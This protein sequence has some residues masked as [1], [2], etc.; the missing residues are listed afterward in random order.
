MP[1]QI[2]IKDEV[3]HPRQILRGAAEYISEHGWNQGDFRDAQTGAVCAAGGIFA[4][5]GFEYDEDGL[6][7]SNTTYKEY[8]AE[9]ALAMLADSVGIVPPGHSSISDIPEWNDAPERT[10]EDVILAMKRA[11]E[12]A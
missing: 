8:V 12:I 7:A 2:V 4:V 6:P 1:D 9:T 3:Q 11:S 5:L 10:A